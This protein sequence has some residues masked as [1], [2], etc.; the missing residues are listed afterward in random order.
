MLGKIGVAIERHIEDCVMNIAGEEDQND[1]KLAES[2]T[3]N[4]SL[5]RIPLS[6]LRRERERER[7]CFA[8]SWYI[9]VFTQKKKS[10]KEG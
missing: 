8:F 3:A 4:A 7:I 2:C 6:I 9:N 10:T 5:E 1:S